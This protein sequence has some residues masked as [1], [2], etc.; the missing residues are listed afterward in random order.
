MHIGMTDD[1]SKSWKRVTKER[2]RLEREN[3]TS[4]QRAEANRQEDVLILVF[5]VS[6]LASVGYVLF[7]KAS[8]D[9]LWVPALSLVIILVALVLRFRRPLA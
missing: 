3:M 4:L 5:S 9:L 7:G 1:F 2:D 6:A 8:T